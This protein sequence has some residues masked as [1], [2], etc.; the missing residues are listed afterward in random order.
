MALHSVY[1]YVH[2][3]S[4]M[5]VYCIRREELGC[6]HTPHQS[7]LALPYFQIKENKHN[8]ALISLMYAG[9]NTATF[10]AKCS[11]LNVRFLTIIEAELII[12]R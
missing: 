9:E 3:K 11:K 6:S 1:M 4:R 5:K 7:F 12:V 2:P 10:V 8:I